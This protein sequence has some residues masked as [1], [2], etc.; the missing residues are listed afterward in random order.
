[1]DTDGSAAAIKSSPYRRPADSLKNIYTS[2]PKK[3]GFGQ[4]WKD[5][6]LG[7]VPKY[8]IDV[9]EGGRLKEKVFHDTATLDP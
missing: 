6:C 5:N 7:E 2:Y 4:P 1:L 9:Y 8:Y 3:G